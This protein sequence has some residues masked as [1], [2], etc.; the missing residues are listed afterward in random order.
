M[1][2]TSSR[3]LPLID[4]RTILTP[5]G[6]FLADGFTHTINAY[7]G[8]GFAGSLCGVFC[9]AQHNVWITKGRP[10]GLYGAKREVREAY[11]REYDRRMHPRRG[12][13]RPL[14]IYMSSSTDPYL[15]REKSLELTRGLLEEMLGR[16]PDTLVIQTHHTLIARDL[17]LIVELSRLTRLWVA[18]TVETDM[19]PVPGFP[20][21]ASS[22]ARRMEVL[23]RFRER[24]VLT[25]AT[26]SPLLPLADPEGFARNLER[27]CDR[28]IVDHYL[29]GDGSPGGLRTRRTDFV[30][31]LE[32]AGFGAW[33]SLDRL[34]EFRDVLQ[35]VLGPSRV[36]VS[37]EGFNAA[38]VGP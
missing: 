7:Q 2:H 4:N 9:Y 18:I 30:A 13:P 27:I 28:A 17:E 37:R 22:P 31:R 26:I 25:Q 33:T 5:T 36:M 3:S 35:R 29:I 34:W 24:G 32:Q 14:R 16:P 12:D 21:H 19:D 6:G 20:R 38:G 8:C 11:R 10:W 1:G 23:R 15:P